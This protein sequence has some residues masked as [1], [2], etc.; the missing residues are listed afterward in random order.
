MAS[1]LK[2]QVLNDGFK[3]TTI[4]IDGF[5]NAVDLKQ[6]GLIPELLGRL[7][8]VTYLNPLD[9]DTLRSI[10]TEPKNSL[11]KQYKRLFE[12]EG[13]KLEVENDV[14]NF[15]VEKALE[16]KLGARG[17]RSICEAILTDAM[18]ELPSQQITSFNLTLEYAKSKFNTSKLSMLKVA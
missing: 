8:V 13:I 1:E 14:L 17:L 6:F 12:I 9:S 16:Y 4:K 18:Y 11:I 10:L 5:V 2:V 3:N 7:P 15:M